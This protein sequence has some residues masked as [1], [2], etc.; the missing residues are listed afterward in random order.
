MRREPPVPRRERPWLLLILALGAAL[1]L[2]GLDWDGGQW[3]HPDERQVYF[4]TLGLGWPHSLAEALSP[5]SPLN[6]H[7]F[8]YGSLPFYL[9]RLVAAGVG[10]LWP[11]FQPGDHLH[12]VGRS[13]AT[14]FDLGTVSLTWRLARRF[15]IGRGGVAAAL[16]SVAVL[17]V[18]LAH[19]YTV[20]PL[21]TFFVLLA[22]NLAADVAQG[23][24]WGRLA[25][26]GV[27][28]GL[29]L[30]T[31]IS[32]LLLLLV[33]FTLG[34]TGD[35]KQ[36]TGSAL[37]FLR[38]N[39]HLP[40]T[41]ALAG[42]FFFLVQPYALI[43]WP[44]FVDHTLR[45]SQI[46]WGT[47][48]APYT[49]QYTGTWPF[50]DSMWQMALWGLGLPLGLVAWAGLAAA[51]VRWLR[52]G[53]PSDALLLAWA[54]P[55]LLLVGL[56]HTHPLRYL[57][58]LLPVLCILAVHL[59]E[60]KGLNGKHKTLSVIGHGSLVIFS[61]SYALAFVRMYAA[62]HPWITASEWIYRHV[63]AGSSLA[64]EDWDTALP[65]PLEVDG[66][67]R[68][69]EEYRVRTLPLYDEPD[70]A[71]KWQVL[72]DRLSSSDY[73]LI[74][75]RRLYGS[76][77]RVPDRYPV[78][79]RYYERL[80]AGELG[81][82]RVGEF[83]RGPTWLNPPLPPLPGAAPALLRPDE[84]F[85]VY[86]HPRTLIFRNT[87]HL[88]AVELLRRLGVGGFGAEHGCGAPRRP[89][90]VCDPRRCNPVRL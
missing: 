75:S 61:L 18:Q 5:A 48:E 63:P 89:A 1:R 10:L 57:L 51:L 54:G 80:F 71:V 3:L 17:P 83:T 9:L 73:L 90:G 46:A 32:A 35:R 2:Y 21:L 41:L 76:I 70:D 19:F 86:D 15:E 88:P 72:A 85:V 27:A 55:Y 68:R 44:T 87:G 52:H 82:E 66:R 29:A 62:P 12:L 56:L 33:V 64:V 77:G 42:L 23:A 6:P 36:G 31:K 58:P 84:S 7:F 81:F 74:A 34:K 65:L 25:A 4:V 37:Q 8:A 50:L 22:L 26:L 16:V 69:I 43:D 11:G 60:G 47:L 67:L 38:A 14:L 49:L 13:L 40:V 45:E 59:L 53:S 30:A 28:L 20:D 78:T 39:L 79:A 24:G